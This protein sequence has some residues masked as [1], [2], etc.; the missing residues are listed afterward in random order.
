V[1]LRTQQI[2]VEEFGATDIAD[3]MGGGLAIETEAEIM[4]YSMISRRWV[5]DCG[6]IRHRL[7]DAGHY[8]VHSRERPGIGLDGHLNSTVL[9]GYRRGCRPACG[10]LVRFPS[11]DIVRCVVSFRLRHATLEIGF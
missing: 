3:S 7:V 11:D 10:W 4:A 6:N 1:A 2:I 5:T 8:R 9:R